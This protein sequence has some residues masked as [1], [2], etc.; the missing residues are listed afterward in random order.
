MSDA[1]LEILASRAGLAVDWI[2]ANGRAQRVSEP[3]LR[4]ILAALGH[5]AADDIAI[6]NSLKALEKADRFSVKIGDQE[7]V[8]PLYNAD[9]T[10]LLGLCRKG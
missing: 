6:A 1:Q 8:F 7:V 2:D 5:P 3:V 9:V 4:R 10:T